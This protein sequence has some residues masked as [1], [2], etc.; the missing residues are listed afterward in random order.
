MFVN[1]EISWEEALKYTQEMS[2]KVVVTNEAA[3]KNHIGG[4]AG[5]LK[6]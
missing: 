5:S 6:Q 1:L 4:F 3:M 2:T